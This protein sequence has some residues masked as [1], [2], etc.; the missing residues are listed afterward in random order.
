[1]RAGCDWRGQCVRRAASDLAINARARRPARPPRRRWTSADRDG[2]ASGHAGQGREAVG[3]SLT[4]MLE[5]QRN[6]AAVD[7]AQCLKWAKHPMA[8]TLRSISSPLRQPRASIVVPAAL[9]GHTHEEPCPHDATQ[10]RTPAPVRTPANRN[11]GHRLGPL[12]HLSA[13]RQ[14]RVSGAGAPWATR[15]RLALV[16]PRPVERIAARRWP[17]TARS[18]AARR[19]KGGHSPAQFPRP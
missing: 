1:V 15:G 12:D 17:L 10:H 14:R 4:V 11:A 18:G 6:P 7:E 2:H 9:P 8:M 5:M 19:V 13:G 3:Q 16:G